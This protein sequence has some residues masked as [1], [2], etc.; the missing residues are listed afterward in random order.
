MEDIQFIVFVNDSNNV[1]PREKILV[2]WELGKEAS[3]RFN[4]F[5]LFGIR[6]AGKSCLIV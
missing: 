1:K 2:L 3:S 6:N 5:Y 4:D